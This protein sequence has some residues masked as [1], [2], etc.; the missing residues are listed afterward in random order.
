MDDKR[1][2]DRHISSKNFSLRLSFDMIEKLTRQAEKEGRS[3]RAI[4]LE[5]IEDYL[6]KNRDEKSP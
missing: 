6:S 5:A 2:T 4:I 3:K 1:K